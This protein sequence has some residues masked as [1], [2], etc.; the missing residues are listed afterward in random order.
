VVASYT[1]DSWGV[2]TQ[3]GTQ[4]AANPWRYAGGYRDDATGYTKFGARYYAPLLGRFNQPDPSAQEANRYLYTAANPTNNT[5]P[6]GYFYIQLGWTLCFFGCAG[7]SF[8]WD[9]A[10]GFYVGSTAGVGF[11]G[12]ASIGID[13]SPL[14]EAGGAD[15][16]AAECSNIPFAG[17]T[18]GVALPNP[19]GSYVGGAVGLG[20]GCSLM[21][22]SY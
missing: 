4:A 21:F 8:G 11:R 15:S 10:N 20:G 19:I 6:T 9:A 3:T 17:K 2:T 5:D 14:G 13:V 18:I 22:T 7:G 12:E 16:I 1:Y